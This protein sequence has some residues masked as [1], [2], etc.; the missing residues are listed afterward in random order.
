MRSIQRRGEIKLITI[1]FWDWILFLR[2]EHGHSCIWSYLFY[3]E[4]LCV[5]IYILQTGKFP[6]H[7]WATFSLTI[8][9]ATIECFIIHILVFFTHWCTFRNSRCRYHI[10]IYKAATGL[11]NEHM[12][13]GNLY[14]WWHNTIDFTVNRPLIAHLSLYTS[15]HMIRK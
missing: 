3:A 4:H 14:I 7:L 12:T 13:R 5:K 9:R 2:A 11:F 10:W 1:H 15:Q 8:I 6:P